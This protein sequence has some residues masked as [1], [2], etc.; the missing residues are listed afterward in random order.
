MSLHRASH[1]LLYHDLTAS[2]ALYCG[3]KFLTYY[4]PHKEVRKSDEIQKAQS[5]GVSVCFCGD[6]RGQL[7]DCL[8]G[9]G[10]RQPMRLLGDVLHRRTAD[11]L[12]GRVCPLPA[13]APL[14]VGRFPTRIKS[15]GFELT[16]SRRRAIARRCYLM[17]I[18]QMAPIF[19]H[20]LQSHL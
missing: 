7:C 12:L 14:A 19:D 17:Y 3:R 16:N 5:T 6:V 11:L 20:G 13:I 4:K 15:H 18:R 9:T 8:L 2:F 1:I 10:R